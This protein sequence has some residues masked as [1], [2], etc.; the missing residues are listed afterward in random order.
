M[1]LLFNSIENHPQ[2]HMLIIGVGDYPF[3]PGGT[4]E[5]QQ[6]FDGAQRLGQLTSP[7]ISA[8][9]FYRAAIALHEEDNWIKPLGSIEVLASFNIHEVFVGEVITPATIENIS[10]AYFAWKNRCDT[11]EENV[12]IFYFCGHGLEK[13]NQFL[14]AEDFGEITGNPWKG[15]FDFDNTRKAFFTCKAKTQLFLV[16]ACRNITRDMFQ[17]DLSSNPIEPPKISIADCEFD[18]TQK[19]A[20]EG[21]SAFGKTNAVSFY[22][23]AL[24][25]AL[26]GNASFKDN[27]EWVVSTGLIASRMTSLIKME[28]ENQGYPQRCISNT[29]DV[30]NIIRFH[31][32]P[33]VPIAITC[34]PDDALPHADLICTEVNTNTVASRAPMEDPWNFDLEAG[35]YKMEANFVNNNYK[36]ALNVDA[37]IPPMAKKTLKC[38]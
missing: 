13:A 26:K 9:A 3:L 24:I 21:E 4:K 33:K 36:N 27:D 17:T 37:V 10:A 12:A 14:L 23:N 29:S 8:E 16:D 15:S 18:L 20:A 7:P 6:T 35:I 19:A 32:P 22:T 25:K 11:H 30:T 34:D 31:S 2:T 1:A 28:K 5:K 38:T